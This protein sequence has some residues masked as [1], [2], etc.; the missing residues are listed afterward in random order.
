MKKQIIGII[1]FLIGILIIFLGFYKGEV[2]K[3][4]EDIYMQT[5]KVCLSCMGLGG[6]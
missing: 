1:F 6:L 3:E 4:I 2:Q 5:I